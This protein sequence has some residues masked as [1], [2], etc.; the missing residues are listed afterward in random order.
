MGA[1]AGVYE[2][3]KGSVCTSVCAAR[4]N[5]G[6]YAMVG[7]GIGALIGGIAGLDTGR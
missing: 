6:R 2:G 1:I 5:T 3:F 4:N 7:G